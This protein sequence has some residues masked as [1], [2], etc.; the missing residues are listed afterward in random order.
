MIN[1]KIAVTNEQLRGV[2][3]RVSQIRRIESQRAVLENSTAISWFNS[4]R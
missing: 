4:P 2:N 3:D 1:R